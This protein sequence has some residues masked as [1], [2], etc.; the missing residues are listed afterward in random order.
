MTI[1]FQLS[2]VTLAGF[3]ALYQLDGTVPWSRPTI[4][5]L[6]ALESNREFD[7]NAVPEHRDSELLCLEWGQVILGNFDT[8]RLW[9]QQFQCFRKSFLYAFGENIKYQL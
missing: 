5:K 6:Y 3:L 4:F 2:A 9:K 8:N 1:L 7:K